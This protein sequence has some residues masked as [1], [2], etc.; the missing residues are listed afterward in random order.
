MHGL[1][2][3][4]DGG[5]GEYGNWSRRIDTQSTQQISRLA[6]ISPPVPK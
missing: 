6:L 3:A 2:F 5:C 4:N 1:Q